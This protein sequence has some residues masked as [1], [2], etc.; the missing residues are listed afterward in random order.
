MNTAFATPSVLMHQPHMHDMPPTFDGF[1]SA[2]PLSIAES[3]HSPGRR[4]RISMACQYCRHR[5]IRCCGGAPCRNCTRAKRECEYAPV[6]EE[7]NRATRE[8]K[9]IAKAAKAITNISPITTSSP[10]FADQPVFNVPYVSGPGPIRPS[11]LGHRRT[12][13]MP[14]GGVAPWVTPPAA[15]ALASPPMF[16]SPQWMYSGWTSGG[17]SAPLHTHHE[18]TPVS[19]FPSVLEQTPTHEAYLN[20]QMPTEVIAANPTPTDT[21]RSSSAEHDYPPNMMPPTLPTSWSTPSLPTQTYLRPAMPITPAS[22]K[23]IHEH[24]TSPI[25]PA[26]TGYQTP[27]PTP[28]L[29]QVPFVMPSVATYQHQQQASTQYPYYSPSPLGQSTTTSPTLAPEMSLPQEKEQLV[30]LGIGVPEVQAEY[31]Q[32]PT[33]TLSSDEYFSP[34]IQF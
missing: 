19:S 21:S 29:F 9:A 15:P 8:K 7:V 24:G 32:I 4:Q 18:H 33:P 20:G 1:G 2:Y 14:T 12:V 5:K 30:G 34:P 28:P 3:S 25:T 16:E 11:H 27:F 6:P 31:Y 26:T 17:V 13:S 23:P 22:H 10:Y